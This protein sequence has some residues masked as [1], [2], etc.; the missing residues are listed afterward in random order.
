MIVDYDDDGF[1]DGFDGG[2]DDGGILRMRGRDVEDE[3][4]W[5]MGDSMNEGGRKE[6]YLWSIG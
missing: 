1:G 2:F 5:V 4:E 6:L 3:K